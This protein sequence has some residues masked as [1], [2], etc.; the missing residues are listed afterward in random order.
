MNPSA[1]R[2]KARFPAAFVRADVVWGETTVFVRPEHVFDVIQYLHERPSEQYD[3]LSA[4]PR[5]SIA[6]WSNRSRV[7]AHPV[8]PFRAFCNQSAARQGLAPQREERVAR[9]YKVPLWPSVNAT[10]VSASSSRATQTASHHLMWE[11]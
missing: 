5:S 10:T 8:H 7:C 4:S 9:V 11:P 3:Y 6:T 2:I 1:D